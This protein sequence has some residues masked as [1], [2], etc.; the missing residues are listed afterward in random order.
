MTDPIRATLETAFTAFGI[1]GVSVM[2]LLALLVTVSYVHK[3]SKAGSLVAGVASTAAHD[4]KVV[5]LTLAGLLVVGVVSLNVG[6]GRELVSMAI[7]RALSFD[8]TSL[9]GVVG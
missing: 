3:A 7:E 9:L 6:R 1:E 2:G 5:A 8:W 4:A